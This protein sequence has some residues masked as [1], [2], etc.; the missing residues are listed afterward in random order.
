MNK[1]RCQTNGTCLLLYV[2]PH[3][4]RFAN[5]S[6][7]REKTSHGANVVNKGSPTRIRMVRRISLGM[8]TRPRSSMRRTIPVA[9]MFYL[10]PPVNFVS[11]R[12]YYPQKSE[13][14]ASGRI[15]EKQCVSLHLRA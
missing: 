5:S 11:N 14:Y 3:P 7:A 9:F 8:T 4:H 2:F 13:T 15:L 12:I 10:Y 1:G 6:I